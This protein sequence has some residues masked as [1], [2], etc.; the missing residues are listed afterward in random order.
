MLSDLC[1]EN[2]NRVIDSKNEK[3][4]VDHDDAE[5]DGAGEDEQLEYLNLS[6]LI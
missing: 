6:E 3:K 4:E 1:V 5:E 2:E